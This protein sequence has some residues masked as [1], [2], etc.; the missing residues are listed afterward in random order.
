[1]DSQSGTIAIILHIFFNFVELSTSWRIQNFVHNGFVW[2]WIEKFARWAASGLCTLSLAALG[3]FIPRKSRF[4]LACSQ[5]KAGPGCRNDA[6]VK[7]VLNAKTKEDVNWKSTPWFVPFS[8]SKMR[9]PGKSWDARSDQM[10]EYVIC[11]QAGI[12][13][14]TDSSLC[15]STQ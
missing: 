3:V 13:F 5:R 8:E 10:Y 4:L 12:T 6:L 1:M 15:C 9:H 14:A 11:C 2:G 7:R